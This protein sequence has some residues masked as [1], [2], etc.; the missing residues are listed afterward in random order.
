MSDAAA[1][2][3][4]LGV[5]LRDPALLEQALVHSSYVNENP[6]AVSGHNERLEFL[7]DAVLD[8]IVAGKLYREFPDL[9]EGAMTK[10]RAALVTRDTLARVAL[11]I[12]LGGF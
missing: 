6:T 4:V 8:L 5:A 11:G 12:G 9:S 7:G 1:L 3:K 10:L 2:Q